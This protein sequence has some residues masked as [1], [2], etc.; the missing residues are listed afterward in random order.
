MLRYSQRSSTGGSLSQT[1]DFSIEKEKIKNE[2]DYITCLKC[3]DRLK[4]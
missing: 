1:C 4:N 3:K 2:N